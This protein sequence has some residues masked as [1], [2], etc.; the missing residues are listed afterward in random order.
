MKKNI[1]PQHI[2]EIKEFS[3]LK[4][5]N[6]QLG[7]ISFKKYFFLD[8]ILTKEDFLSNATHKLDTQIANPGIIITF[9]NSIKTLFLKRITDEKIR[10]IITNILNDFKH[11]E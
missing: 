7:Y 3:E 2:E 6:Q 5:L 10:K 9:G 8:N 1:L 11:F 4:D